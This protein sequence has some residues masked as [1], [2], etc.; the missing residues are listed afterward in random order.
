MIGDASD[1]FSFVAFFP[2]AMHP[3]L[4]PVCDAIYSLLVQLRVCTPF[5]DE[6]IEA[7][8]EGAASRSGSLPGIM[9][10]RSSGG[11]GRRAE[12]ERRRALALRALNQRLDAGTSGRNPASAV[13]NVQVS[14]NTDP[15]SK[16]ASDAVSTTHPPK[17]AQ[18]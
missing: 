13:T 1:T 4:S 14:L 7:G 11:G 6:A 18:A 9:D 3:Y 10:G 8:N 2:D 16:T 12:A 15:I 5:S 17:E